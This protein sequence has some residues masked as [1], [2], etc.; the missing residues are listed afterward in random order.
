M[1]VNIIWV[2]LIA[3]LSGIFGFFTSKIS[4]FTFST[5]IDLVNLITL[6]VTTCFGFYFT[7]NIQKKLSAN[8]FEKNIFFKGFNQIKDSITIIQDNLRHLEFDKSVKLFR[9][10]SI[11]L[12]DLDEYNEICSLMDNDEISNL[13][14]K[15]LELKSIVTGSSSKEN[16][17]NISQEHQNLSQNK[18]KEMKKDIVKIIIKLNRN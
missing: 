12:S 5:E 2:I 6:V 10:I 18:I 3:I 11:C 13:K 7:F 16:I 4:F 1:K 8:T 14:S 9:E 17:L 15:L